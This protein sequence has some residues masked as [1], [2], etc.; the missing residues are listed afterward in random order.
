[1]ALVFFGFIRDDPLYP[2]H[3]RSIDMVLAVNTLT[4]YTQ[5]K[6][7]LIEAGDIITAQATQ[8]RQSY[9]I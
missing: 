4:P 6:T 2:R 1:L 5:L 8:R 7:D 9:V 3:P